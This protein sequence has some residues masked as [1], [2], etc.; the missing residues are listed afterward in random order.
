[1]AAAVL[2]VPEPLGIDQNGLFASQPTT[3]ADAALSINYA[4]SS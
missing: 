3:A 2:L 1:M 4:T